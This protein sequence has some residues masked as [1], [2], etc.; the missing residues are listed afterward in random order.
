MELPTKATTQ[1][2]TFSSIIIIIMS[3]YDDGVTVRLF[4]VLYQTKLLHEDF[5]FWYVCNKL[6]VQSAGSKTI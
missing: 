6:K 2:A 1:L 4:V 5:F 3:D